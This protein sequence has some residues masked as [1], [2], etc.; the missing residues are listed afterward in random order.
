MKMKIMKTFAII[1][2]MVLTFAANMT[3]GSACIISFYQP[4]VPK[5]LQ[6]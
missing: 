2:T 3:V 5:S 1:A 4:K 6:D